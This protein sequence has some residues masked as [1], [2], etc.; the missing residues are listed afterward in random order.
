M[1]PDRKQPMRTELLTLGT[2]V[3]RLPEISERKLSNEKRQIP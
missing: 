1:T 3:E 2:M